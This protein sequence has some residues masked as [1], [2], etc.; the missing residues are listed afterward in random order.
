MWEVQGCVAS[1]DA[2]G[3]GSPIMPSFRK[4]GVFQGK[5]MG[6]LS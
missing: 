4:P 1:L 6:E 2:R 5:L 3:D